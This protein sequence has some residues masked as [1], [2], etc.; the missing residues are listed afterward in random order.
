[1]KKSILAFLLSGLAL[2]QPQPEVVARFNGPMPTGVAVSQSGRIFVNFPRWGD[3]V[4]ATVVEIQS[5]REVPFP[6]AEWAQY[7]PKRPGETL[8]SVQSVV[9]DSADRLWILDTGSQQFGPPV[10]GGAKL[11]GVDLKT[12]QV[13]QTLVFPPEVA[14]STT[15]LND[16][17]VDVERGL[18]YITDSAVK[19]PNA[20]IVADLKS[21][22][23]WRKLEG[24]ASVEEESSF[25][26]VVEG[27]PLYNGG[28]CMTVGADGI[29]LS[30]QR[31]RLYYCALSGRRLYS[32]ATSALANPEGEAS[33]SVRD[34]GDKGGA[35]DGLEMGP[36]GQLYLTNY[37]QASLMQRS[38]DGKLSTLVQ[39]D[40]KWWPD[41]LCV[42]NGWIYFT[43]NQLHRGAPFQGQGQDRRE[44]PYLLCRQSLASAPARVTTASGLQYEI[45]R[46]G[47]GA[48]AESGQMVQVHYTGRFEDGKKFDSSVDR[49]Q[50]FEFPLGA[51]RVIPGW[52]EGVAGMK[53]GEK[54]RLIIPGK[55]GYGPRGMAGVIPPNA[56]LIFEVELLGIR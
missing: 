54:R 34:E 47:Q 38:P 31:D 43:L 2:A 22:R 40:R 3:N 46:P 44:K 12:N 19:G 9:V 26:P 23:S 35:S 1:M 48:V 6:N 51:G 37:E 49:G 11:V 10:A 16:V 18:A 25:V 41:T 53:V 5:G 24:H 45:L 15:Y 29:A 52:D 4:G 56:T 39:L 33:G 32:V 36:D 7:D 27:K 55:L 50:P 28:Q 14:K 21:G 13:F 17:R 42:R 30:P 8:V 20:I